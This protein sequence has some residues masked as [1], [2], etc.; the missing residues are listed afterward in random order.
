MR[1]RIALLAGIC[2]TSAS[3]AGEAR[4]TPFSTLLPGADTANWQTMELRGRPPADYEVVT[5][6]GGPVLQV[7]AEQS[8]SALAHAVEPALA[9]PA[10]LAWRWKIGAHIE[11][12]DITK[13]SGDDFPARVYVTFARDAKELPLATRAKM[14]LARL[15][16]GQDVPAAAL[17]YVWAR[18]LPEGTIVPNAY[19]D[20]VMMIVARSGGDTPSGWQ[21][22]QRDLRADYRAAFGSEVDLVLSLREACPA[23]VRDCQV[24]A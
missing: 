21:A 23:F 20:T 11:A 4:L 22:E 7:T 19:S 14:R 2:S 8:A 12:S 13:K 17:C 18:D 3:L 24:T 15:L 5:G 10:Q 1:K 16:Y 9:G 6:E